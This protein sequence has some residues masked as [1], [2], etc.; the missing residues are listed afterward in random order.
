MFSESSQ[1]HSR[2]SA[3]LLLVLVIIALGA[4]FQLAA[5]ILQPLVVALL[6]SFVLSPLVDFLHRLRVPRLIAI[7]L[8]ILLLLG[9]GTFAAF[10]LYA[11]IQSLVRTFPFYLQ[12]MMDLYRLVS[13]E[14]ELPPSLMTDLQVTRQIGTFV[15][16]LS[17]GFLS[18]LGGLTMV[19]IFLLFILLEKPYL[20]PKVM[21]ALQGPRTEKIWR[22]VGHTNA[23]IGRYLTVKLIISTVTGLLVWLSFGLIGVDFAFLWGVLSFLF[24]FIPSIGSITIGII[25]VAFAVIQFF[26][27]LNPIVGAAA[28]MLAIQLILGN[29]IDP[30]MQGDSLKISPV[31][32]L[33][34]LL[35]WGWLWGVMGLFLAVP[36]TVALKIVFE[37][38]P[39]FEFVGVLMGRSEMHEEQ[40]GERQKADTDG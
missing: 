39:G 15:V 21:D 14:F 2:T 33:F 27:D 28:S 30:K 11:T 38:I 9:V 20:R 24:N 7:L 22:I 34:S 36:L 23:Q 13:E 5:G 19:V 31:V 12:R 16:T 29:V 18:I 6:L 4:V 10:I 37:N 8:V 25:S 17:S 40:L 32:I 3:G 35:L 26:P 1:D